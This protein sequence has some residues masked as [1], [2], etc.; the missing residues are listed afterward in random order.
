MDEY[1]FL[2]GLYREDHAYCSDNN[3]PCPQ[4]MI[5]RGK[6]Y[7]YVE[8]WPDGSFHS[9]LTCEEGARLRNLDLEVA[10]KDAKR[11]WS[12]GMVPKRVTPKSKVKLEPKRD[13]AGYAVAAQYRKDLLEMLGSVLPKGD[14]VFFDTETTG[15]PRNYKAPAS[16]LNNWPR[17]VQI[18]WIVSNGKD[19]LDKQD[20]IIR[21]EGFVIPTESSRIHGIT[22]SIAMEKGEDLNIVLR[23]YSEDV[24][25]A[26]N[27]V[28]HNVD[29]DIKVSQAECIRMGLPNPFNGKAILDTMKSTIDFCAIPGYYGY[30]W[31]KLDEL[32]VKLFGKHFDNAHNS[33]ADI[34]A[35]FDCYWRLKELNIM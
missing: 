11:W 34:Q 22:Q 16:D 13:E 30:K 24:N 8:Q 28:G 2:G 33:M 14:F 25:T 12:T 10:S 4:V 18:S 31:P 29:F 15:V 3:C 17:I 9:Q 35:T 19:I 7:I 23:K 1:F 27:V 5:P 6:G 20:H 26:K 32:Y 21:P